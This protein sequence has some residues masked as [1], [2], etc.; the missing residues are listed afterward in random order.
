MKFLS[1]VVDDTVNFNTG[2]V[3]NRFSEFVG[4]IRDSKGN[5]ITD[6]IDRAERETARV[7]TRYTR[8]IKNRVIAI[9]IDDKRKTGSQKRSCN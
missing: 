6:R 7:E 5:L 1:D 9:E 2:F 4:L 3:N 8:R